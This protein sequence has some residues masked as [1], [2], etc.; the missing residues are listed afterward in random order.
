MPI[1]VYSKWSR[2]LTATYVLYADFRNCREPKAIREKLAD[3]INSTW[4]ELDKQSNINS[5]AASD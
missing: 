3:K 2:V 1:R 4:L 5:P